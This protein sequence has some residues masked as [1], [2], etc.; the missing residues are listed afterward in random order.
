[1]AQPRFEQ[2]GELHIAGLS[3]LYPRDKLAAIP[4]QWNKLVTQL[5]F[6][7][8]RV[9]GDTYGLWYD[10]LSGGDKP[11]L[12]V[13]GVR[14]GAFAPIHPGFTYYMIAPLSCAVFTHQGDVS[15]IRQTV[16]AIFSQW[17]PSSGYAHYRQNAEAPDFFERY[18]EAAGGGKVGAIE[19]WA[20]VKK[21]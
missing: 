16:E 5:Q 20:P 17:L 19:I 4:E 9:G 21:K 18:I 2:S 8:G 10:V 11:M 15:T 13:T 1:L 14:V 6:V 12:Y 3:R 7:Q